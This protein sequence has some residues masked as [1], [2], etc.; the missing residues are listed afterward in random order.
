MRYTSRSTGRSDPMW[1]YHEPERGEV[2]SGSGADMRAWQ[3]IDGADGSRVI[4][5]SLV[6]EAASPTTS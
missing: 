3:V 2:F 5:A 4:V 6:G 1:N